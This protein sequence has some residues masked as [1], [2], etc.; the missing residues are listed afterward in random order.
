MTS[1][2]RKKAPAMVMLL[3]VLSAGAAPA[4]CAAGWISP[5]AGLYAIGGGEAA[6][7]AFGAW[8][9]ASDRRALRRGRW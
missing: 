7:V 3:A 1:G 2:L 9:W 8:A 4:A 5:A 6:L